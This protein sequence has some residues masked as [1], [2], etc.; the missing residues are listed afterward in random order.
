[1]YSKP[2]TGRAEVRRALAPPSLGGP[3]P[4]RGRQERRAQ[5]PL[6][7]TSARPPGRRTYQAGSAK[8]RLA[9][10]SA[11]TWA[12]WP[13]SRPWPQRR[14]SH[15]PHRDCNADGKRPDSR[16]ASS[17]DP[18]R[19]APPARSHPRNE[20]KSP[21]RP[22]QDER[23]EP[24]PS[25]ALCRSRGPRASST[26]PAPR[27]TDDAPGSRGSAGSKSELRNVYRCGHSRPRGKRALRG[28]QRAWVSSR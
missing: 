20:H 1:M 5:P 12:H 22:R 10:R 3:A 2:L 26:A 8:P 13:N 18:S 25:G 19:T 9:T 17:R 28:C 14:S 21:R 15:R 16:C 7:R 6:R 4:L 27:A 11:R 23:T 24:E